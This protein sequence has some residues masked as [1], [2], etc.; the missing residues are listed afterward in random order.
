ME[1]KNTQQAPNRT[2][3]LANEHSD[4]LRNDDEAIRTISNASITIDNEINAFINKVESQYLHTSIEYISNDKLN[5]HFIHHQDL[6]QLI[7]LLIQSINISIEENNSS[8]SLVELVTRLLVQQQINFIPIIQ[9]KTSPYG[10]VIVQ[11]FFT[12]FL[13]CSIYDRNPSFVYEPIRIPFNYANKRVRLAQM[14][15]YIGT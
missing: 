12:S 9:S 3:Q 4:I 1:L 14:P 6:L 13:V 8:I 15:A 11:L 2:I 5:L 10:V 7:Q